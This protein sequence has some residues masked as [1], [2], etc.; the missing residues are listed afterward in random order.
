M[1]EFK[2]RPFLRNLPGKTG[3]YRMLDSEGR[4]IYVDKA[5]NLKQR[6][7]SYFGKYHDSPKTRALVQQIRNIEVTVT[8]TEV[9]ALLLENNLI[10]ELKP[11][12]NVIFRDDKSYPYLYLSINDKFPRLHYYRGAQKGKGKYFGPYPDS[13]SSRSTLHLTQCLF[14]IRPCDD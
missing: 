8:H 6:V 1:K 13:G 11:R 10:K 2:N 4:V 5:R 14:R 9:E 7:G 12:Y 3:V